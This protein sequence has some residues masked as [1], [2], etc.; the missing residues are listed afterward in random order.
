[1]TSFWTFALGQNSSPIGKLSYRL[2]N[3]SVSLQEMP[4]KRYRR[5]QAVH[6]TISLLEAWK[7]Q[8]L[9]SGAKKAG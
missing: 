6:I 8:Q 5:Q 9:L 7:Q 2:S 1:L 3:E 4:M